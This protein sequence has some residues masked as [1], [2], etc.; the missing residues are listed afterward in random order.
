MA[1]YQSAVS[2]LHIQCTITKLFLANNAVHYLDRGEPTARA[3]TGSSLT[4]YR[5]PSCNPTA[6]PVRGYAQQMNL[7][8]SAVE[9]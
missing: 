8:L 5:G 2:F 4:Y 6:P 7:E 1:Y 9:N 3:V